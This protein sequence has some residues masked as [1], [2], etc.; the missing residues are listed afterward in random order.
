LRTE[1][2]FVL[3]DVDRGSLV[4]RTINLYGDT[5]DSF[6]IAPNPPQSGAR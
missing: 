4:G 2:H 5:F 3:F 6:V 1:P